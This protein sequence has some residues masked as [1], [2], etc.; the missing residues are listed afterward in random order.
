MLDKLGLRAFRDWT[1][2]HPLAMPRSSQAG[3][4]RLLG[5]LAI[6]CTVSE[7]ALVRFVTCGPWMCR[8]PSFRDPGY[9]PTSCC[10]CP[11]IGGSGMLKGPA[12][13]VDQ[14]CRR[15]TRQASVMPCAVTPV[16]FDV[17]AVG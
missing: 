12:E 2:L 5:L 3:F 8:L 1:C 11:T 17:Q 6:L 4:S 10:Q 13:A 9:G 14:R 15:E 7:Y 16:G